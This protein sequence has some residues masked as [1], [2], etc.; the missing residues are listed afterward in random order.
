M[1]ILLCNT[2]SQLKSTVHSTKMYKSLIQ[3]SH[4][5]YKIHA[6]RIHT[7]I[8]RRPTPHTA[9]DIK[10]PPRSQPIPSSIPRTMPCTSSCCHSTVITRPAPRLPPTHAAQPARR[11]L[12]RA[13]APC[14]A[15]RRQCRW[16]G[17]RMHRSR[18]EISARLGSG[19]W[20]RA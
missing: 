8:P 10:H 4:I 5:N 17:T 6:H 16:R 11:A 19:G 15:C 9:S 1:S 20:A 14:R 7:A 18:F 2:M 13:F 12:R 3:L